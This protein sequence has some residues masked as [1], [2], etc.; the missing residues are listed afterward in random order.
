MK[1]RIIALAEADAAQKSA[2]KPDRIKVSLPKPLP[3]KQSG[4]A[5][6]RAKPPTRGE[7][8]R[9]EIR[10]RLWRESPNLHFDRRRETGFATIPRTL[11][12]IQALIR[13]L[14]SKGDG[15]AKVYGELWCRVSDEGYVQIDDEAEFAMCSGYAA[16]SRH[17]RSWQDRMRDL[18]VLGLILVQA[19][20]TRRYG[21]VLLVHP[22]YWVEKLRRDEPHRIP[23]DWWKLYLDR[24]HEI[25]AEPRKLEQLDLELRN[26]K[27]ALGLADVGAPASGDPAAPAADPSG[28][29]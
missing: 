29:G 26:A 24:L 22:H 19:K 10:A 4:A 14:A 21:H 11:S 15:A 5:H 28:K 17:V 18:E 6:R 27:G 12:L 9:Q 13:Q 20:A 2:A 23:D 16:G 8:K 25:G 3:A 1:R 7:I